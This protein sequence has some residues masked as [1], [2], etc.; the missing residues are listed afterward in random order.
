METVECFWEVSG[1]WSKGIKHALV[2]A[3]GVITSDGSQF[4]IPHVVYTLSTACHNVNCISFQLQLLYPRVTRL[5]QRWKL[6][7]VISKWAS[8][9]WQQ[10]KWYACLIKRWYWLISVCLHCRGISP[11]TRSILFYKHTFASTSISILYIL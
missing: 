2:P 4:E 5:P 8:C 11:G 9:L 7:S 1:K 3:A 6:Y 10:Q